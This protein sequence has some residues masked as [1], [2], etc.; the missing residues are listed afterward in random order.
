VKNLFKAI[1]AIFSALIVAVVVFFVWA[2]SANYSSDDYVQLIEYNYSNED[3]S[4]SIFSVITYNIGYL[5]GMTNNLP[6]PKPKSLFNNNLK[7]V[8]REFENL[9][10]DIICLQEVDFH[11]KRSYY[12]NQQEELHKLGYNFAFQA[13]NWDKKYLPFPYFPVSLQFGE[14]YS[15]QSI[16]SKYQLIDIERIV[17]ERGTSNPFYRDAFYLDRLA[18][19]AKVLVSGDTIV[20]INVHLEAFDAANRTKQTRTIAN[21]YNNYKDDFPVLL[22][23]DFNSDESRREASIKIL[24]AIPG[25]KSAGHE[26]GNTFSSQN[27]V[28]RLDYIFYNEEFI[29][30][31]NAE[32]L[33]S[34]GEASDHLPVLMEFKLK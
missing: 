26:L 16:L 7:R 27:P 18:Q 8:Y 34:I 13:A 11:S 14:V 17:L 6:V 22:V 15:G 32:I 24:L 31:R 33:T 2:S 29:E 28:A 1:I 10:A 5:S 25:L 20:L 30:M 9:E 4:D 21:L 12:I 3:D 23:G 19:V